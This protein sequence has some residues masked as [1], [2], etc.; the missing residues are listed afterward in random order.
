MFERPAPSAGARFEAGRVGYAIGDIHGRVD[1]LTRMLDLVAR[2]PKDSAHAPILIFLGDYVDRGPD[3]RAV[4]N[5]LMSPVP[6]GF[7]RRFLL[8]NHEAA[9]MGFLED[10]SRY[11]DWLRHGGRE[12]LLS[13]GVTPPRL[14]AAREALDDAAAA[15]RARLPALHLEFLR[16][17]ERSV[18]L[19][20]YA[21]VHAGIDPDK[22]FT[23]QTDLDLLWARDKFI[24]SRRTH[25][26]V[27]VHG[28]TPT[29]RPYRDHRRIGLDTG[30]YATGRLSAAKFSGGEVEFMSVGPGNS[31]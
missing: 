11:R 1:L 12:T 7:E 9:M 23:D 27:V 29:E 6:T 30:A 24:R 18:I 2:A 13:Y 20:D 31:S 14:D 5:L 21:F 16:R 17:L 28:H 26:Y 3:S 8:G 25:E 4:L 10:P 22:P 19:G 15:F